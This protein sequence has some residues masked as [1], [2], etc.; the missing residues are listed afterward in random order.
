MQLHVALEIPQ[1]FVA[2]RDGISVTGCSLTLYS[3]DDCQDFYVL[4]EKHCDFTVCPP[5]GIDPTF[6]PLYSAE[7]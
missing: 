6:L 3:F 4:I 1:G 7:V 2:C 5:K